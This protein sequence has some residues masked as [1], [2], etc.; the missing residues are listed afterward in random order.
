[1]ARKSPTARSI[2]LLESE[3][4]TVDVCERQLTRTVKKDLFGFA[5]LIGIR[6]IDNWPF[7]HGG[8]IMLIQ[9]T[10]ASTYSAR[11]KKILAAPAAATWLAAGGLIELHGWRA[12]TKRR[13]KWTC[14]RERID[15]V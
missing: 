13:K 2:E 4:W 8:E 1:M 10:T 14:R 7:K 12:P 15:R 3:G 9:P 11:R 6:E 5:D